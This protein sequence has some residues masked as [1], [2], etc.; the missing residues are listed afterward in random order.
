M[1]NTD[2]Y[3]YINNDQVLSKADKE[4]TL[5]FIHVCTR[6]W[7][8]CNK[9]GK[10]LHA[11]NFQNWA[12]KLKQISDYFQT[13]G[14]NLNFFLIFVLYLVHFVFIDLQK[15]FFLFFY[16]LFL[17]LTGFSSGI[18]N[19]SRKLSAGLIKVFR[20]L[21]EKYYFGKE[22]QWRGVMW[23]STQRINQ[24]RLEWFFRSCRLGRG[25][26]D[27]IESKVVI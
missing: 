13:K 1:H 19:D 22:D 21:F 9:Y 8:L 25:S 16:F 20:G 7:G 23:L 15:Q 27:A 11:R 12:R 3:R 26:T 4:V 14:F 10:R 6:F 17:F 5:E 2:V 24:D 18:R